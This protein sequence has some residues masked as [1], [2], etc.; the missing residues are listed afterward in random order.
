MTSSASVTYIRLLTINLSVSF[1]NVN[2]QCTQ[3]VFYIVTVRRVPNTWSAESP[4]IGNYISELQG[5]DM[6][7]NIIANSLLTPGL[8][9]GHSVSCMTTLF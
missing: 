9:K 2:N 6:E 7:T 4:V 1:N 3:N 8:M 5:S